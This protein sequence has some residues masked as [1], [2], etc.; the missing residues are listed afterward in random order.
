MSF[1]T[2]SLT[3]K[4]WKA[5]LDRIGE[6]P[7]RAKS[8]YHW[9]HQKHAASYDEMT[10]LSLSLRER[11]K[12]EMPLYLPKVDQVQ[13]SEDGSVCKFLVRLSDDKAVECVL[14]D[15]RFGLSLCISSQAGCRMGCRFCASTLAGLERSLTAGEML[16]QIYTVE[17]YENCHISHVVVMGCGEPFDN[18]TQV[19]RFLTMINDPDGHNMSVRNITVSTCGLPD[20]IREFADLKTGVT[21]A[22]SLHAPNDQTRSRIM[23]VAKA[24]S[25]KDLMDACAYY[26][27]TTNDRITFEYLLIKN[28]NDSKADALELAHLLEKN[29]GGQSPSGGKLY[30]VNLIPVNPV[31]ECGFD[32]P[33]EN[34][35]RV[36]KETLEMC[37]VPVTRRREMGSGIDAACGQLRAKTGRTDRHTNPSKE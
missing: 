4:E 26:A 24:V 35:I 17:R 10:D 29:L 3:M 19:M 27:H 12:K 28:L 32:R 21:M 22:V 31:K 37:R 2:L 1:D 8:I 23:K 11:L 36:F 16:G 30:H 7:Y 18:F 9:L 14:M 13:R 20:K 33:S 5:Y 34:T 6:K 15:Y 25:M